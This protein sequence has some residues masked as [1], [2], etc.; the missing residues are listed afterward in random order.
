VNRKVTVPD[1]ATT[2]RQ[3]A[4]ATG[5]GPAFDGASLDGR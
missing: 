1:G 5:F 2:A 4:T 3:Y